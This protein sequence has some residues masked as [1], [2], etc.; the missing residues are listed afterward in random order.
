MPHISEAQFWTL[1][2]ENRT[3]ETLMRWEVDNMQISISSFRWSKVPRG[4]I[5]NKR[6]EEEKKDSYTLWGLKGLDYSSFL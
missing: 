1:G 4:E 2:M 6:P 5:T 3:E